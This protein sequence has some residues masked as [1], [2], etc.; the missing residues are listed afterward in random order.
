MTQGKKV[1]AALMLLSPVLLGGCRNKVPAVAVIPRTT[2]TLL[3]EP[4]HEGVADAARAAG[5]QVYWNAPTDEGDSEK[6][7]NLLA[8]SLQRSYRGIILAPDETLATRSIVL[9]A[10]NSGVPMVVVDDELGPPAGPLLSYVAN[11]ESAGARMAAERVAKVLNRRGSIAIIG[12]SPR[13]ESGLSREENFESELRTR[14]PEIRIAV[15]R[16]GDIVVTHQQQIAQDILG[17]SEPV[18]A[19]VALTSAATR[20]AYY[21]KIASEPHSAVAIVG[22]D[23]DLLMPVQLGEVDS[24]VV[25][26]TR[27]IGKVAMENLEAQMRGGRVAARTNVAPML[28]TRENIN[29]AA[30]KRLWSVAGYDWSAK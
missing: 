25:Q 6:Q 5:I 18:D 12:I 16:F 11:D 27:T 2:A 4:M 1:V 14:A 8:A 7:V 23:Q 22:F 9:Q 30:A 20:G 26:D 10:I 17:R 19:I 15:R 13:L 29:S 28:V 21:A 24:I 3:W